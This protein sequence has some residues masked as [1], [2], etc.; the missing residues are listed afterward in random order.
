MLLKYLD[1]QNDNNYAKACAIKT[2]AIIYTYLYIKKYAIKHSC[3]IQ[4][5]YYN[6]WTYG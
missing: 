6:W 3:K 1:I 4:N 5:V 2:S